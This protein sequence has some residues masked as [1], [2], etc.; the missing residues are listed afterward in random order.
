MSADKA[1]ERAI[2]MEQ[3]R[4]RDLRAVL[5]SVTAERDALAQKVADIETL[6]LDVQAERDALREEVE[7]DAGV[8][9]ALRRRA[10]EAEDE[11]AQLREQNAGIVG[12][13]VQA[14]TA[15]RRACAAKWADADS[16]ISHYLVDA[17][18]NPDPRM[19]EHGDYTPVTNTNEV[20]NILREMTTIYAGLLRIHHAWA[21]TS[22]A[23]HIDSLTAEAARLREALAEVH[24]IASNPK[25]GM[26]L[27]RIYGIT[28]D[29]TPPTDQG[30]DGMVVTDAIGGPVRPDPAGGWERIAPTDQGEAECDCLIPWLEGVG[31]HAPGCS[32]F[33]DTDKDEVIDA[34][35]GSV[36]ADWWHDGGGEGY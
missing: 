17:A 34:S 4:V 21:L 26:H 8:M 5:A 16:A 36:L 13:N 35:D 10:D 14:L 32:V 2:G 3:A 30:G 22:A 27:D 18:I 25:R 15:L 9:R 24:A 11:A 6:F 23:D 31:Q 12:R 7:E 20:P 28:R 1:A 33:R 29:L 19:P